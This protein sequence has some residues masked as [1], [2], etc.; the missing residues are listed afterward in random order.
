MR[1]VVF[2][3]A[4]TFQLSEDSEEIKG[5]WMGSTLPQPNAGT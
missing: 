1:A 2:A 4:E 5:R 3:S